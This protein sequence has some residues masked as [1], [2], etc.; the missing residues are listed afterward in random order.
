MRCRGS[1]RV[2]CSLLDGCVFLFFAKSHRLELSARGAADS[3]GLSPLP[4]CTF[5]FHMG[6]TWRCLAVLG[7]R[8][9]VWSHV[10]RHVRVTA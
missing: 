4:V 1:G 5:H 6:G 3:R 7:G 8:E 2:A 9:S 10:G